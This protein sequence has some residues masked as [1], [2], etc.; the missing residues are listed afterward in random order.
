MMFK[1]SQVLFPLS[2]V[3]SAK[4]CYGDSDARIHSTLIAPHPPRHLVS[5]S[6]PDKP[7]RRTFVTAILAAEVAYLES[8]LSK[9]N[10]KKKQKPKHPKPVNNNHI[11]RP[12]KVRPHTPIPAHKK[13]AS[14]AIKY[15]SKP[16]PFYMIRAPDLSY[17]A[18]PVT[19]V[20]PLPTYGAYQQYKAAPSVPPK[21]TEKPTYKPST[22]TLKYG[23]FELY[24]PT[25]YLPPS[26][27]S[28]PISAAPQ[29][30]EQKPVTYRPSYSYLPPTNKKPKTSKPNYKPSK[31]YLPP[32]KQSKASYEAPATPPKYKPPPA[33]TYRP[34]KG[35][36]PPIK[37]NEP[38]EK[39][40][41]TNS[42]APKSEAPAKKAPKYEAPIP[43]PKYEA[44]L[45]G[46]EA[47]KASYETTSSKKVEEVTTS[48]TTTAGIPVYN[49][50]T[51]QPPATYKQNPNP[52]PHT[53][54]HDAQAE[55]V[56]KGEWPPIY[57]NSLHGAQ[58]RRRRL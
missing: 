30:Q 27:A 4:F 38:Q 35:Y 25:G 28:P 43:A 55:K 50:T 39:D 14:T 42:E 11:H 37:Q 21:T 53:F 23:D 41:Q 49:P 26:P 56:H 17:K 51:T 3:L 48:T 29:K 32:V 1:F 40:P 34:S 52:H 57:Y 7:S 8:L 16:D 18:A 46:T 19:E 6:A 10:Q 24:Q 36:L 2:C 22:S 31:G 54:F 58:R 44:P 9:Q 13:P 45:P 33:S 47:P 20:A 5:N 12:K 15:V